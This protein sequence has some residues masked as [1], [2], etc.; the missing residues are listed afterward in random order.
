MPSWSPVRRLAG[1]PGPTNACSASSA[2]GWIQFSWVPPSH[3]MLKSH[4]THAKSPK[5]PGDV[6]V[7][8]YQG[9]Q[10]HLANGWLKA[11]GSRPRTCPWKH[12]GLQNHLKMVS[13]RGWSCRHETVG[14]DLASWMHWTYALSCPCLP[15]WRLETCS[16]WTY[17]PR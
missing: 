16:P 1:I 5:I 15:I 12:S 9:C 7:G 2:L 8:P 4:E 6:Q 11:N 13:Q 17:S 10:G 3:G 14:F